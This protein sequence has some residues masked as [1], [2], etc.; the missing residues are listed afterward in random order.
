MSATLRTITS[1]VTVSV[2]VMGASAS[3]GDVLS[4]CFPF[5]EG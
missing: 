2:P 3:Q 1:L 5:V 4:R